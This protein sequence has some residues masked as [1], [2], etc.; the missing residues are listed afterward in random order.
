LFS[1]PLEY[2]FY[3]GERKEKEKKKSEG[4][5][6]GKYLRKLPESFVCLFIYLFCV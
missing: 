6:E 4:K 1:F 2:A 5:K 3:E